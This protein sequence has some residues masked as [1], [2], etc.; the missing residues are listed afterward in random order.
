MCVCEGQISFCFLRN[1]T[2]RASM[3][4]TPLPRKAQSYPR[5]RSSEVYRKGRGRLKTTVC[6]YDKGSPH[7]LLKWPWEMPN[8]TKVKHLKL[9]LPAKAQGQLRIVVHHSETEKLFKTKMRATMCLERQFLSSAVAEFPPATP[10]SQADKDHN[11]FL[12]CPVS[13]YLRTD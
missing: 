6:V 9:I 3:S 11:G 7:P 12:G 1:Y 10:C 13:H 8:K 2:C 5:M 4:S